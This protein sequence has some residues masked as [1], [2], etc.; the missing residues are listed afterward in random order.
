MNQSDTILY[1]TWLLYIMKLITVE[2]T[3]CAIL[4]LLSRC[5]MP[6]CDSAYKMQFRNGI[7]ACV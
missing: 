1:H 2:R 6:E 5:L 3:S 7:S 4:K